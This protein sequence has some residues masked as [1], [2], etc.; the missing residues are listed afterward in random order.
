VPMTYFRSTQ[1][2]ILDAGILSL[3]IHSLIWFILACQ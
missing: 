2:M 1:G 3:W